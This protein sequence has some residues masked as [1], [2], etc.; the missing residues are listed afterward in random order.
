MPDSTTNHIQSITDS[1]N[2]ITNHAGGTIAGTIGGTI[3]AVSAIQT[4]NIVNTMILAAIGATTS[5]LVTIGVKYVWYK[6]ISPEK[7][8]KK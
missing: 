2:H 7:K 6:W 8:D 5:F 4:E 1:T 3:V